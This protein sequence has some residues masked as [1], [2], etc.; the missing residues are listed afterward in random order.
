MTTVHAIPARPQLM[1]FESNLHRL[2]QQHEGEYVL[3]QGD[4]IVSCF[5]QYEEALSAGYEQ[6]GLAPFFVKRIS[7]DGDM[8]HY[9]RDL[10]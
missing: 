5:D 9:T 2:L 6:F 7:E 1:V 3:I 8:V 10:G 4:R